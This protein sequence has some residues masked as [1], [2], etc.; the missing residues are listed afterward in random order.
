M[1]RVSSADPDMIEALD[2]VE[3]LQNPTLN[4]PFT[5]INYTLHTALINMAELFNIIPKDAEQK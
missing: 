1:S 2:L 3:S 4:T 5:T